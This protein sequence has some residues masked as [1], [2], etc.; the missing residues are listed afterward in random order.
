MSSLFQSSFFYIRIKHR[1]TNS[2]IYN[3]KGLNYSSIFI[4]Q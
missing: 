2:I 4:Q 1:L 3:L